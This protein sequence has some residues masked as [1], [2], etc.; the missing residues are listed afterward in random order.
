MFKKEGKQERELDLQIFFCESGGEG[1]GGWV[2]VMVTGI[3]K[4]EG[5]GE[6]S[7]SMIGKESIRASE[8][9]WGEIESG[10]EINSE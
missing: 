3:G 4:G 10:R 7:V 6:W 1:D 5:E 9:K 8:G 2:R